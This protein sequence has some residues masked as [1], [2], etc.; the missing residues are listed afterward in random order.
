MLIVRSYIKIFNLYPTGITV[1]RA[2]IN[3]Q[4]TAL[5]LSDH[6][7]LIITNYSLLIAF[8]VHNG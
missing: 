6:C 2:M 8:L 5:F 4:G 3:E 7:S 1:L